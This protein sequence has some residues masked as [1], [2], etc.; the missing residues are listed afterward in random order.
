MKEHNKSPFPG[1]YTIGAATVPSKM[2]LSTRAKSPAAAGDF[3][4]R[5]E[6]RLRF[7]S[8]A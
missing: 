2:L 3:K 4:V 8:P 6:T 7:I 5:C 1:Q